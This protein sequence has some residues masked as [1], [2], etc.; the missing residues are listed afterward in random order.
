[1]NKITI[2][3]LSDIHLEFYKTYPK[4]KPLAKYLFLAGDIGTIESNSDNKIK[5]FLS[6]CSENWEKTFY[7]LGNHEFYQLNKIPSKKKSIEDLVEQ[8][9]QICLEFPNVYLLN[10]SFEEIVPGLNVY[11][12]TFWTGNYGCPY[13][14]SDYLNDYNMIGIKS[15]NSTTLVNECYIDNLSKTQFE[16]LD[17]YLDTINR[18]DTKTLIMTHFPPIREGSSNPKYSSQPKYLANYF[19]WNNIPD[20]LDCSNVVG[21]ISGH[22][23]WSYDL[24][25]NNIRFISNQT[26][27]KDEFS[28]GES[29]FESDKVFEI[30]Y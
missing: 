5:N 26:G 25:R 19:S 18:S 10:N 2:Q 15:T 17:K 22:T 23:H 30:D 3:V 1:M 21:W 6:Y 7:V 14:L 4:F 20:K 24:I 16:L 27:Y 29:K 13:N 8:Y 11:G 28:T 9:T 12:S